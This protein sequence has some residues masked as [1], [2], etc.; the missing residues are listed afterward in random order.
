MDNFNQEEIML[1]TVQAST[2]D[3]L[4][5]ITNSSQ[6][7]RS[8]P[9]LHPLVFHLP[10]IIV[11]NEILHSILGENRLDASDKVSLAPFLATHM[12]ELQGV[13][14]RIK[15]VRDLPLT[16]TRNPVD[17]PLNHSFIHNS[18]ELNGKDKKQKQKQASSD[19]SRHLKL[20]LLHPQRV[21]H[22]LT[23]DKTTNILDHNP[24]HLHL[25]NGLER[26][27]TLK[28][29]F[30]GMDEPLLQ[31]LE[32]FHIQPG[33]T[34]SLSI[35]YNQ[36]SIHKTL[37]SILPTEALPAP[38]GFEQIGHVIHLNLKKKHFPHRYMIGEILL[39]RFQPII[40]TIVNKVG[41][42]SG[43]FRTYDMEVLA[44][45]PDTMVQLVEDGIRLKFD[46]RNVYWCTRLSGE[47][48]YLMEEEFKPKDIIVDAF[49]GVGALCLQAAQKLNA[50]VYANDLNPDAIHYFQENAKSNGIKL[51]MQEYPFVSLS[52][53]TTK[54]SPKKRKKDV[55]VTVEVKDKGRSI[56][57]TCS[58]AFA[59]LQNV[60]S[61]NPL[62]NHIVMNYPLDS[63]SFLGALRWWPSDETSESLHNVMPLVHLYTFAHADDD[64]VTDYGNDGDPPRN[65]LDVAIDLVAD[66]L[67]PEGGALQKS[68]YRKSELNNLGCDVRARE[69]RDVA[70][71]KVVV[72]VSLKV[73]YQ[74]IRV[75]QGDYKI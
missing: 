47:R 67:I 70:P 68:R 75:M 29:A 37:A 26:K 14:P 32:S 66:G 38:T 43:P 21:I 4:N 8:H 3:H 50:T 58:D 44:G 12:E 40:Q 5:L 71:G 1:P 28:E 65:A 53:S 42:V 9:A 63:I 11:P 16:L 54:N 57:I 23:V 17:N 20:I 62:P 31:Y 49:C 51:M 35:P 36:Q 24:S 33:P 73:T 22:G 59:F 30:P 27:C 6:N 34:F 74:L 15:I 72:C 60:G 55:G 56:H 48:S 64:G 41:E 2:E 45:K 7:W 46:L 18:E 13:H 10:T 25:S 19:E 52:A 61:M 39:D 69:V